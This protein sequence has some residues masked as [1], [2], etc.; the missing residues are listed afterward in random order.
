MIAP[1]T[2]AEFIRCRSSLRP[3]QTDVSFSSFQHLRS[4]FFLMSVVRFT[5]TASSFKLILFDNFVLQNSS[6]QFH[7]V[8]WFEGFK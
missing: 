8:F 6:I 4:R 7:A 1:E 3:V 2:P 5:L